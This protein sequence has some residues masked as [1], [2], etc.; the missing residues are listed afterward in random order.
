MMVVR[1][2]R[3][4]LTALIAVWLASGQGAAHASDAAAT[5]QAYAAGPLSVTLAGAS[6]WAATAEGRVSVSYSIERAAPFRWQPPAQLLGRPTEDAAAR[7]VRSARLV[8]QVAA[9]G[10]FG[11]AWSEGLDRLVADLRESGEPAFLMTGDP[12]DDIGFVRREQTALAWRQDIGAWGLTAS[13]ENA[14]LSGES[15]E[16]RGL[17]ERR[18]R[19]ASAARYGVAVDRQV[20]A[21]L[22]AAGASRLTED[23]TILGTR[24]RDGFHTQGADSLFFDGAVSLWLN[25]GFRLG[26]AWR[27]GVTRSSI[28]GT[29]SSGVSVATNGWAVDVSGWNVVREGD[30]LAFRVSQPLRVA[31]DAGAGL[32]LEY[33]YELRGPALVATS[34]TLAPTGR[35]LA[36]ELNWRGP[37]LHGQATASLFYRKDPGHFS[38][39]PDDP[40]A[41][42]MW[43][44][45]F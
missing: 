25:G 21:F 19:P 22:V 32:P 15:S 35:E 14:R 6:Q 45:N 24:V 11:L 29:S 28:A 43:S 44:A 30:S 17:I 27:R 33:S 4:S 10:S 42:F 34:V 2:L 20:G 7:R 41:A 1:I 12:L 13:V 23:Q 36:V 37:L 26:A 18:R 9:G 3:K 8:A 5:P 31:N 40:G 16:Y 38:G 39:A